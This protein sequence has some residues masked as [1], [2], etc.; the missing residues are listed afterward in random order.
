M[1]DPTPSSNKQATFFHQ[2]F[3]PSSSQKLKSFPIFPNTH[4]QHTNMNLLQQA[5]RLNNEGLAC[6]RS[7]YK[8]R[9]VETL[10][11]SIKVVKQQLLLSSADIAAKSHSSYS[12][13]MSTVPLPL[14]ERR[15]SSCIF[16]HAFQ[17]PDT[18]TTTNV[19]DIRVY[20]SAVIFNLALAHQLH[21]ER[22][23]L[24]KAR[25]LYKMSLR[26]LESSPHMTNA[27]LSLVIQLACINNLS[28]LLMD[29]DIEDH[30]NLAVNAVG[31]VSSY[32]SMIESSGS[33]NMDI[34]LADPLIEGLL[35]NVML[36]TPVSAAPAA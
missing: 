21:G 15:H 8:Q 30:N 19:G 26:L 7:G 13:H 28:Q 9:G 6:F 2:T 23:C 36:L 14:H 32:V 17:I 11:K 35:T 5:A 29:V 4:R 33:R 22:L 20:A 27:S 34:S 10:T 25:T 24:E 31:R 3:L 1:H 12:S 18:E 16:N